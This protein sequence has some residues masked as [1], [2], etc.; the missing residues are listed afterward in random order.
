MRADTRA[1]RR[2]RPMK[3]I[4]SIRKENKQNVK[5]VQTLSQARHQHIHTAL[6]S[7]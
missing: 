6:F 3:S 2:H 7:W 1:D 4:R 5:G